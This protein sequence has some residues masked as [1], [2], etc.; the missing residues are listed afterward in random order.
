MKP[1]TICLAGLI[2]AI[3]GTLWAVEQTVTLSV[4]D[5]N[6]PACPITVKKALTRL[7]GVREVRLDYAGRTVQVGY[8]DQRVDIDALTRATRDAGYP[9]S[10]VGE[11]E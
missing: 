7:D 6:C 4:P 9:S 10:A 11:M 5:T 1:S 8:D 2:L 3:T